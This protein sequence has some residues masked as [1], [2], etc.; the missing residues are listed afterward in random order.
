MLRPSNR[1]KETISETISEKIGE[2]TEETKETSID[3]TNERT[4]KLAL[5]RGRID[6]LGELSAVGKR[7]R[8]DLDEHAVGE[9]PDQSADKLGVAELFDAEMDRKIIE[10]LDEKINEECADDLWPENKLSKDKRGKLD[11]SKLEQAKMTQENGEATARSVAQFGASRRTAG[12]AS[13][14]SFALIKDRRL[15][16]RLTMNRLKGNINQIAEKPTAN[17]ASLP[18]GQMAG[19]ASSQAYCDPKFYFDCTL[20]NLSGNLSSPNLITRQQTNRAQLSSDLIVQD[21]F[22]LCIPLNQ[23]C[24]SVVNC[25][26]AADE[27]ELICGEWI[28][29]ISFTPTLFVTFRWLEVLHWRTS[30]GN[31][32]RSFQII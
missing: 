30:S 21:S 12:L 4:D 29:S 10:K 32:S 25:P 3:E 9:R 26:N 14:Q 31:F 28:E 27:S 18:T 13:N 6:E 11:A 1:L 15:H 20:G 24:D 2:T 7:K 5:Y 17:A 8:S 22:P 19:N 23:K 16:S